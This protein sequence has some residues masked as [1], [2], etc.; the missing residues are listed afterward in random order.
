MPEFERTAGPGETEASGARLAATLAPGDLVLV[1]GDLG[2]GKTTL[3]RG[4]C[5][6]LGVTEPVTSPTF[7]IG[8]RYAGAVPVSHLDFFRLGGGESA[9]A[10]EP[11]LLDEYLDPSSIVFAEWPDLAGPLLDIEGASSRVL[12]ISIRHA[13]GDE[14]E[15]EIDPGTEGAG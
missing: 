2:A 14:R 4:A 12:R 1:T 9:G 5:R 15:I 8:H 11:G 13:G 7:V 3:I 10:E 6:A